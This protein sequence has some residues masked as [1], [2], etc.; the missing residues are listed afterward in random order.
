MAVLN[1][2]EG[3]QN[4]FF[5]LIFF[6]EECC[7]HNHVFLFHS[8]GVVSLCYFICINFLLPTHFVSSSVVAFC[9]TV[10]HNN[11]INEECAKLYL[12]TVSGMSVILAEVFHIF[13]QFLEVN[14]SI[15]VYQVLYDLQ[16]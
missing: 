6:F 1:F 8:L 11:F 13:S 2:I 16:T 3:T 12:R 15:V 9:C 4:V 10:M 14:A 7:L 5:L